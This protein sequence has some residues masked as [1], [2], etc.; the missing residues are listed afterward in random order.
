MELCQG[1]GRWRL[2]IGSAPEGGEHGTGC[3]GQWARPQA[4]VVQGALG[5]YSQI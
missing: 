4:A 2:G 3:P 1:R 5:Q